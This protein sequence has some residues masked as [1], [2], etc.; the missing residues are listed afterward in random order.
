MD[1]MIWMLLFIPVVFYMTWMITDIYFEKIR[2]GDFER[3][4][5]YR[6][7]ERI[8]EPKKKEIKRVISKEDPYGEENWEK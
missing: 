2:R 6:R 8:E 3:E 5:E 7:W 1:A 4:R